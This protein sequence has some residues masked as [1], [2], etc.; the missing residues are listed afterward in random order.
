M[1]KNKER[2]KGSVVEQT[3]GI[4]RSDLPRLTLQEEREAA[5]QAIAEEAIVRMRG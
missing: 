3:A 2:K 1:T 5:K 4:M